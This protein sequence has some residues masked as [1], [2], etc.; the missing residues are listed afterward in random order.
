MAIEATNH[1]TKS[2]LCCLV[3]LVTQA[4][5]G[6]DVTQTCLCHKGA[7]IVAARLRS[8]GLLYEFL[9]QTAVVSQY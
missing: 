3:T 7:V 4:A 5:L 1:T 6:H 2:F 9:S 8:D